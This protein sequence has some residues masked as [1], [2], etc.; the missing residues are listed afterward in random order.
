MKEL[1]KVSIHKDYLLWNLICNAKASI[2]V[3]CTY[4]QEKVP[5]GN[6]YLKAYDAYNK[7]L[8]EFE[9]FEDALVPCTELENYNK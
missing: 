2:Q 8:R 4:M 5:Y 6:E 7:A 9:K 1:R 3:I